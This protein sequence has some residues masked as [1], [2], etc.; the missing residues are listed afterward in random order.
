MNAP[1]TR[2]GARG[3]GADI[4]AAA[5]G[6]IG[7]PYVHQASCK[8]AGAD[9]LGLVRGVWREILGDEPLKLP[10]YTPDWSEASGD[11]ALLTG[12]RGLLTPIV[13]GDER[14][15]DVIVFRMRHGAV[16]KHLGVLAA[17]GRGA[18]FIHAYSGHGVVE[19]PL[20]PPWARR[21]VAYF[22]FPA[23]G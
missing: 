14:P 1:A 3:S 8:G 4:V 11:E 6:W 21:I 19:S 23:R 10:A 15:G 13:P 22:R 16:A 9:C 5:R 12:A 18:R 2:D 7:T 17:T 20:T